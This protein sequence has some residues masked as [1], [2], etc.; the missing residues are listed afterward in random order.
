MYSGRGGRDTQRA[1][2]EGMAALVG[3][4]GSLGPTTRCGVCQR[5]FVFSEQGNCAKNQQVAS[6]AYLTD[7][8]RPCLCVQTTH[9]HAAPRHAVGCLAGTG[10]WQPG[11]PGWGGSSW[12]YGSSILD[13]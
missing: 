3:P 5:F 8:V 2:S 10:H 4:A 12:G 9:A 13:Y 1:F 7:D 6:L 11:G